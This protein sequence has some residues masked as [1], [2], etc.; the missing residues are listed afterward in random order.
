MKKIEYFINKIHPSEFFDKK[1]YDLVSLIKKQFIK[2]KIISKGD[3]L[4]LEGDESL[5]T[6][7][8]IRLDTLILFMKNQNNII[9][10]TLINSMLSGNGKNLD[11]N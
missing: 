10:K 9:N 6:Q 5:I 11:E 7:L 2:I 3:R 8:I 1:D 4:I